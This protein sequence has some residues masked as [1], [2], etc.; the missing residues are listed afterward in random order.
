[1]H[2]IEKRADVSVAIPL[3]T[4]DLH[5]EHLY[6]AFA[7]SPN[8]ETLHK[9]VRYE[10]Y[11]PK[12]MSNEAW[13]E[14]L[15]SDVDNLEHMLLT[16][17]LTGTFLRTCDLPPETWKGEVPDAA[18]FNL[19]ERQQLRLAAIMHDQAESLPEHYDVSFDI[20]TDADE[21]AEFAAMK[22]LIVDQAS[23]LG[24]LPQ[25]EVALVDAMHD[26][27]DTVLKDRESKVGKAFNAVERLG[28]MRTGM[29]A[30][31]L[32][33]KEGLNPVTEE[34]SEEDAAVQERKATRDSLKW[35]SSN[36]IGNQMEKMIEYAKIYPP[37]H[38]FLEDRAEEITNALTTMPDA[39]FANY[40]EAERETQMK[41][42]AVAKDTWM[43]SSFVQAK[44]PVT[45]NE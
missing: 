33:E 11:K 22:S 26:V 36:V 16:N 21:D 31:T 42:F 12:G 37:I 10:R 35:L 14:L 29:N 9:R 32:S 3:P 8:G 1:M 18:T 39:V 41:K 45:I 4:T 44:E 25:D 7:E 20:K 2:E 40:N 23:T 6:G 17:Q 15:G 30:W 34:E 19:Q 5:V 43:K 24:L 38:L 28:Y 13:V 27:T